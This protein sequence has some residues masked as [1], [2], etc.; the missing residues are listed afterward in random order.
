MTVEALIIAVLIGGAL[1]LFGGGGSVL[2]VPAFT[3]VLGIPPKDAVVMSLVVVGFAAAIGAVR[4]LRRRVV[5]PALA[6]VVGA[7]AMIGAAGGSLI[8]ARITGERQLQILAVVML[9]AAIMIVRQPSMRA[10]A[11]THGSPLLL[12]AIG[13]GTGT[14]TGMV[15][16]GGGFLIV[17]ALVVGAGMSMQE[18]AATSMFVIAVAALSALG[19]YF[20]S[21]GVD[22]LFILPLAATAAVATLLGARVAARL[23]Q[24][25]LQRAFAISLVVIGSWVWVRA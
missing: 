24:R 18:A 16:V 21:A 2:A 12:A 4:G 14:L 25:V 7:S 1:G 10:A 5:P 9:G 11:V 8:G 17:P 20:T 19:G 13:L 22:W 23:P 3:F 6:L 15:G